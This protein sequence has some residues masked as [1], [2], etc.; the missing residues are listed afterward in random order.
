MYIAVC[1]VGFFAQFGLV[2]IP[3]EG[4]TLQGFA[5]L[6][7]HPKSVGFMTIPE[8]APAQAFV[9]RAMQQTATAINQ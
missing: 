6:I 4:L 3:L 9:Q 2:T 7:A 1:G 8:G 5:D